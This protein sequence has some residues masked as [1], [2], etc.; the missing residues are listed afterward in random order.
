MSHIIYVTGVA[1]VDVT[2]QYEVTNLKKFEELIKEKRASLEDIKDLWREGT[3][4]YKSPVVKYEKVW[5]EGCIEDHSY[6]EIE[7][8]DEVSKI[9]H[10]NKLNEL[11]EW[12]Q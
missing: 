3:L 11:E 5:Y 10:D 4:D 6:T 2:Y 1:L 8:S 12:Y 9:I 7:G